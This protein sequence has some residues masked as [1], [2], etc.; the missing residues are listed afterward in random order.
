MRSGLFGRGN[1]RCAEGGRLRV[2]FWA[3]SRD[4]TGRSGRKPKQSPQR[5]GHATKCAPPGYARFRASCP[6]ES[7]RSAPL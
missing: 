7:D 2:L 1:Q 6:G 5:T 3:M 4:W